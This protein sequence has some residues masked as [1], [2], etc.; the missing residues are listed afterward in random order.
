MASTSSIQYR[1]GKGREELLVQLN[2]DYWSTRI[3][4]RNNKYG[5]A[6]CTTSSLPSGLTCTLSHA[7]RIQQLEYKSN[8]YLP[9]PQTCDT[10]TKVP[11]R[12]WLPTHFTF[13]GPN[14]QMLAYLDLAEKST[15]LHKTTLS[16]AQVCPY[17]QLFFFV[18]VCSCFSLAG[19]RV[20]ATKR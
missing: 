11:S 7:S 6:A 12:Q 14:S 9:V 3:F 15:G 1:R 13:S 8:S 16:L 19:P 5:A 18:R 20:L 17:P 10:Q 4:D 2:L